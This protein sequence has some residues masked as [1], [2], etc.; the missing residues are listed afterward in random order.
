[1]VNPGRSET[2][3]NS[4][5]T[6]TGKACRPLEAFLMPRIVNTLEG[7]SGYSGCKFFVTN[8]GFIDDVAS[9]LSA[10]CGNSLVGE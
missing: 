6:A 8:Y 3:A 2:K 7:S 5:N 1:M 4:V 10:V 9:S